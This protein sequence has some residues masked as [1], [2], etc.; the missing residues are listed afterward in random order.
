MVDISTR[1]GHLCCKPCSKA[2]RLLDATPAFAGVYF[3]LNKLSVYPYPPRKIDVNAEKS[4][5]AWLKVRYP[6]LRLETV[7]FD[8]E[9]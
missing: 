2:H 3:L 4:E 7:G 1:G 8:K 9:T 6:I 5:S